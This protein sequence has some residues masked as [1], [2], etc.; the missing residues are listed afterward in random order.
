MEAVFR[1]QVRVKLP[2]CRTSLETADQYKNTL[3][4]TLCHDSVIT[5]L[6]NSYTAVFGNQGQ[7]IQSTVAAITAKA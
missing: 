3:Q 6:L 2:I 5:I 1:M 7:A 4:V